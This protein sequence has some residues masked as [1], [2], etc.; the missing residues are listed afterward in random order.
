MKIKMVIEL[1]YDDQLYH[2]DDKDSMEW[3]YNEI[4][5]GKGGLLFLHSNEIGD[6]VGSVEGIQ[7][8]DREQELKEGSKDE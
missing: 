1:E 3:F 7:I 4:L 5:L 2:G 6:N 8:L